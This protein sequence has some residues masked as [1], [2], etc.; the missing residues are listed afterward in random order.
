[1]KQVFFL[2]IFLVMTLLV[3]TGCVST[4][5]NAAATTNVSGPA[6]PGAL[7]LSAPLTLTATYY[8]PDPS[9][10]LGY[11]HHYFP[12]VKVTFPAGEYLR[13]KGTATDHYQMSFLGLKP[14]TV[15]W[16]SG[17]EMLDTS[18][19]TLLTISDKNYERGARTPDRVNFTAVISSRF[20]ES[21]MPKQK[22]MPTLI[23]MVA[24]GVDEKIQ[25]VGKKI[26]DIAAMDKPEITG[27]RINWSRCS[28]FVAKGGHFKRGEDHSGKVSIKFIEKP[29]PEK[30]E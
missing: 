20:V 29:S 11:K 1:M 27:Y 7:V 22:E 9:G 13:L 15:S 2:P 21:A 8:T 18:A 5:Q 4:S 28:D 12:V 30:S 14:A 19:L 26:T 6:D 23:G 16:N 24:P 3:Q 25:N 10:L 17:S